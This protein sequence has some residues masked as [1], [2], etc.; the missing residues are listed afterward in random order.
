MEFPHV[1]PE[2]LY[3]P[4]SEED[5]LDHEE[6]L[7]SCYATQ[8]TFFRKMQAQGAPPQLI[9]EMWN[10]TCVLNNAAERLAQLRQQGCFVANEQ[11][12]VRGNGE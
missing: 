9:E 6:Y 8:F 10:I 1:N 3:E 5:V 11:L 7:E 12:P 4:I 2:Q